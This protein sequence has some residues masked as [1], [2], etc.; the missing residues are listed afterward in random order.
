MV[1]SGQDPVGNIAP[2]TP[3]HVIPPEVG[4]HG[5]MLGGFKALVPGW[6]GAIDCANLQV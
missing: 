6:Q 2:Q 1:F 4:A 3:D 5:H